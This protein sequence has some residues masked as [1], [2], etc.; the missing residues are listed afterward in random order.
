MFD[1]TLGGNNGANRLD[2]AC[3][4]IDILK[5]YKKTE[6][7]VDIIR[8]DI[9]K[10]I[11]QNYELKKKINVVIKKYLLNDG[12]FSLRDIWDD[13]KLKNWSTFKK[14]SYS[15]SIKYDSIIKTSQQIEEYNDEYLF[16]V[17]DD[18]IE[19][20]IKQLILQ[21][22]YFLEDGMKNLAEDIK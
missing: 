10:F 14:P 21:I 19:L 3:Y 5:H 18:L 9:E 7:S 22:F 16:A 11:F 8:N 13:F 1:E 12:D 15:N 17:Y 6:K 20:L 4:F 2:V